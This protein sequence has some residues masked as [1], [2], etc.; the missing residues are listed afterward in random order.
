M[1]T[2]IVDCSTYLGTCEYPDTQLLGSTP[3]AEI[4]ALIRLDVL[5]VQCAPG[6]PAHQ[7]SAPYKSSILEGKLAGFERFAYKHHGWKNWGTSAAVGCLWMRTTEGH[8]HCY[9]HFVYKEERLHEATNRF[10]IFIRDERV[11][12]TVEH[13]WYQPSDT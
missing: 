13:W 12:D 9:K 10:V 11:D 1:R 3:E 7:P 5:G 2:S 8:E 6:E 4:S